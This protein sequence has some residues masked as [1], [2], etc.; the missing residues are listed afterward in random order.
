MPH[1]VHRPTVFQLANMSRVVRIEL[2]DCTTLVPGLCAY[3]RRWVC[4]V[5]GLWLVGL[6]GCGATKS[7]TATDQLLMSDA[8]DATVAKV[9]FGPLSGKKVYLD[10]TYIK[11]QK[12]P[13]LIDSDYVISSIRQQMVGAGVQIVENRDE[14][15]LI[16]EA[17]LG[18]LGLDGHN[19][20]YG[21]PASNG[22]AAGS[23]IA[24][25]PVIPAIPEIAFARHEAKSGAAKVAVFAYDRVS[26][27]P[28]WQSGLAKSSS[29]S[30]DTWVLG[31]GPWQQGTIY[32]RTRF[33]GSVVN[34][35]KALDA[36]DRSIRTSAA[37]HAYG[38]SRLYH[39]NQPV[40]VE[41]RLAEA[42]GVTTAAAEKPA[43]DKP[44]APQPPPSSGQ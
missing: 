6:G 17:R 3:V 16:A 8:V 31:I 34:G 28:Y 7:Y 10:S 22:F 26:R 32:N 44:A 41:T 38:R 37:F 9:D 27:E 13:L 42:P 30:H 43:A 25:A 40:P 39:N 5:G 19:V 33:A 15:E 2:K 14:A 4:V 36:E 11:T 18:A 24:G 12:G 23:A 29:S 1:T 21:I 35:G 20:I